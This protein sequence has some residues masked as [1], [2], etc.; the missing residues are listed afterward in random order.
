MHAL[1]VPIPSATQLYSFLPGKSRSGLCR[2]FTSIDIHISN[3][4]LTNYFPTI[5]HMSD[6]FVHSDS[7]CSGR[8][9]SNNNSGQFL[10]V[11]RP[12]Q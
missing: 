6:R 11:T 8:C 9:F 12:I 1:F 4:V 10:S 5:Y 2:F 7:V 3:K